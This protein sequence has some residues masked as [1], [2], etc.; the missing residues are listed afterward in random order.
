MSMQDFLTYLFNAIAL[1]F[2]AITTL[3]FIRGLMLRKHDLIISPG[4][5]SLFNIKP[6]P[7]PQL[8]DPWEQPTGE[9]IV[10][11]SQSPPQLEQKLLL[12]SPATTEPNLSELLTSIDID[13]LQIRPARKIAKAL[14]IAQKVNGRDQPLSWLRLQIKAKLH[15]L[16]ELPL[17]AIEAVRELLAS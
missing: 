15:Q 12:L 13:R 3:D 6:E 1:S 9:V 4:Q 8:P 5:L 7:L 10:Q 2:I 17:D 11:P 14:G 16:Q